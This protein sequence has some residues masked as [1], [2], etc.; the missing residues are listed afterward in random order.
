MPRKWL[1]IQAAKEFDLLVRPDAVF[2]QHQATR[3]LFSVEAPEWS[4]Q[5]SLKFTLKNEIQNAHIKELVETFN[6]KRTARA[7]VEPG[8][9]TISNLPASALFPN[10]CLS[11]LR[12]TILWWSTELAKYQTFENF[13]SLALFP[14]GPYSAKN[15]EGNEI[16]EENLQKLELIEDKAA[17]KHAL[18]IG[19]LAAPT[20]GAA[21]ALALY[22]LKFSFP[23]L[24]VLFL[25]G[26][27]GKAFRSI[28]QVFTKTGSL[29]VI[30]LFTLLLPLEQITKFVTYVLLMNPELITNKV[31]ANAIKLLANNYWP[32]L[33]SWMVLSALMSLSLFQKTKFIRREGVHLSEEHLK[34]AS[35]LLLKSR[36]NIL[37]FSSVFILIG[38]LVLNILYILHDVVFP[39][40]L[41]QALILLALIPVCFVTNLAI[42]KKLLGHSPLLRTGFESK[43]EIIEDNLGRFTSSIFFALSITLLV[44]VLNV[45]LDTNLSP[46]KAVLKED[47]GKYKG[48]CSNIDAE[49]DGN[50]NTSLSFCDEAGRP[51]KI[52]THIPVKKGKG[53]FG[54]P[55]YKKTDVN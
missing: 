53:F 45:V 1:L 6:K 43:P 11:R 42:S 2:G 28:S 23:Y 38:S 54:I 26:Q 33:I 36:I 7:E 31:L 52:E 27:V 19:L 51:M 18:L 20:I 15:A 9:L 17:F 8:S 41:Q 44:N 55:Y 32:P 46:V 40:L 24:E 35:D 48:A 29:L 47:L 4:S 10:K 22:K 12:D 25:G 49:I 21:S 34:H 50:F 16:H 3:Q 5:V 13:D 14:F 39:S 37:S 30:L